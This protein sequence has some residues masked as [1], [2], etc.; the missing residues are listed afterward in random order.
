LARALV[1]R[2]IVKMI[3]SEVV[4]DVVKKIAK[5][6]V[7]TIAREVLLFVFGDSV[8]SFSLFAGLTSTFY[9]TNIIAILAYNHTIPSVRQFS[10][11]LPP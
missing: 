5:E 3:V 10:V 8:A 1:A 11:W 4:R 6:V 7:K 9:Y 2:E